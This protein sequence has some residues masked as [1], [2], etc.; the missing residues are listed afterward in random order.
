LHSAR[1][2]I[3]SPDGEY[4]LFFACK[5]ASPDGCDWWVSRGTGGEAM[6]IGGAAALRDRVV[7]SSPRL[8]R[9][10]G[11]S[12]IFTVAIAEKSQLWSVNLKPDPWRFAETPR[13]LTAD[14]ND[15][16]HPASGAGASIA[17][18]RR[19][20]N[21]DV[22]T[23]PLDADRA[24]VTGNLARITS[25]PGV[26]Q[27]PSLS[28]DGKR[29]AWESSRSGEFDVW[30]KDLVSGQERAIT[31][32]PLR[33]HMPA[34][35]RN[36]SQLVYDTHDGDKVTIL[37]ADFQGGESARIWEENV[38]QGGFQWS[39]KGDEILYFH[40]EPPGSVGLMNLASKKRRVVLRHP[41]MNLS[42]ADARLSPDGEWIAFP[43]PFA[44]HRSRL[45]LARVSEQVIAAEQEW[46]YIT[47][48]TFNAS[49]PEWAPNGRWLYFLSD[50]TKK[51][52]VWA[53]ALSKQKKPESAPRVILEFNSARLTIDEMRPRDIG[54]SVAKDK[55]ALGVAEYT[56][57]LWSVSQR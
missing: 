50:Q 7:N 21:I 3:W 32:G 44:P 57:T 47:P 2:A 23:L 6:T 19:A 14:A 26:D 48:E 16:R 20:R 55:L 33:E 22:W 54:L 53:L 18:T 35:S 34:L 45:A 40:R 42:L 17:F 46:T 11:N 36:G 52:S 28:L 1:D 31:N 51:L 38:G 8:W 37:R 29:V 24:K 9:S 43:V 39:P 10:P 15:E 5:S 12:I 49:Q 13:R 27:R 56:G 41:K 25:D 30:V 4:L